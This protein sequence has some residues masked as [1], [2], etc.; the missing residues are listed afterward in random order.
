MQKK[1]QAT[2]LG[3]KI[4]NLR[5]PSVLFA[6]DIGLSSETWKGPEQDRNLHLNNML[7]EQVLVI[8]HEEGTTF[9]M[10]ISSTGSIPSVAVPS[11][12]YGVDSTNLSRQTWNQLI[13]YPSQ[14][15]EIYLQVPNNTQNI[16]GLVAYG[17]EPLPGAE[18]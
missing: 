3:A 13:P 16:S 18:R 7:M 10:S 17:L 12:L 5:I 1:L 8:L 4:S 14:N 11:I 6:D 9:G 2:G 15:W